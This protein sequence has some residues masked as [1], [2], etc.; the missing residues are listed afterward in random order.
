MIRAGHAARRR[1]AAPVAASRDAGAALTCG[2]GQRE[3]CRTTPKRIAPPEPAPRPACPGRADGAPP[4]ARDLIPAPRT[5][6]SQPVR[7]AASA[8]FPARAPS[9]LS[10]SARACVRSWN[11][12]ILPV[13]VFGSSPKRTAFGIL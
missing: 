1:V 10:R 5:R 7:S 4:Q 3:S 13:D 11:F 8:A 12:W 6:P 9:S 2:S